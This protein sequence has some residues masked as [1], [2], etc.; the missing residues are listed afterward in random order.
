MF[1]HQDM[2]TRVAVGITIILTIVFF[3]G[4]ANA[5]LPR[6]SYAKAIDWYLMV[7]FAFIFAALVECRPAFHL[8]A[9]VKTD[10]KQRKLFKKVRHQN[11]FALACDP[12]RFL[13][14]PEIIWILN[15]GTFPL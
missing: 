6:V 7:S 4:S 10:K 2:N 13:K 9:N 5:S 8:H 11:K 14:Y 12:N 3:L 15:Y 1:R